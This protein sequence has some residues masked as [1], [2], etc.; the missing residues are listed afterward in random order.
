MA[1]WVCPNCRNAIPVRS[2][3]CPRCGVASAPTQTPASSSGKT[4][5]LLVAIVVIVVV[6]GIVAA[7]F[8]T[9]A[10][11]LV[12]GPGYSVPTVALSP[13]QPVLS[14]P[15]AYEVRVAAVDRTIP[16]SEYRVQVR[17]GTTPVLCA[18]P[19]PMRHGVLGMAGPMLV[20]LND[21]DQGQTLTGGD[22]FTLDG[23]TAGT[24]Y[25]LS[26][27][28]GGSEIARQDIVG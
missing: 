15:D 5:S 13:Q 18:S 16:L 11:G 2:V 26:L 9:L 8:Y 7:V 14:D 17:A 10:S 21:V 28:W 22:R 12:S 19:C 23:T 1:G 27:L 4:S 6:A 24:T 20:A 3:Q 25:T